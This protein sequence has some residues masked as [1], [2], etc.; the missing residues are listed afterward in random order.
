MSG[1]ETYYKTEGEEEEEEEESPDPGGKWLASSCSVVCVEERLFLST[2]FAGST[3][4]SD[5]CSFSPQII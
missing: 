2:F 4:R 1:W 3:L 5:R